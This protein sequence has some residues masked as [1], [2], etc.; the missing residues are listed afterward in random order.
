MIRLEESV[1]NLWGVFIADTA[2]LRCQRLRTNWLFDLRIL[3][4]F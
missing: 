1:A 2:E 3:K 4:V